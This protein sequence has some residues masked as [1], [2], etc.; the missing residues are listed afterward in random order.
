[1]STI[2]KIIADFSTRLTA[3]I[4]I[5]GTSGVLQSNLDAD[6][7]ALPDGYYFFTLDGNNAS[8]EYIYCL[9]TGTALSGIYSVSVQGVK[10]SGTK[11]VH[12]Y[13]SLVGLTNFDQL[14]LLNDILGGK[15]TLDATTPLIYDATATISN[16]KHIATKAYADAKYA[17]ISACAK[18]SATVLG[19]ALMSVAPA[20]APSPIAVGT[21]DPRIPTQDE[22]NAMAGSYGSPSGANVFVTADNSARLN[23]V[24]LSTD[25]TIAGVKTFTTPPIMPGNPASANDM[26]NKAYALSVLYTS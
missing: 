22:N 5:G 1:M 15:D 3:Q 20:S 16:D 9:K 11:R 25:Q 19:I 6:G 21:L 8:K 7:N 14:K 10:T 12:R 24:D 18:A 4:S 2:S 26:A 13:A 17:V 23:N